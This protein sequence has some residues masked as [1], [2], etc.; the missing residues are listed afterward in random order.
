MTNWKTTLIAAIT[1][2]FGF[3]LFSPQYFPPWAIDLAK[4]AFVGGLAGLGIAAKDAT[5]HSTATEVHQATE[6]ENQRLM[7]G[8]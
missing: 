8:K 1:A 6:D 5:V 7:G 3:V 4:Y 2:L